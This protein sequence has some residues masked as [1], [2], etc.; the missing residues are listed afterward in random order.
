MEYTVDAPEFGD[1]RVTVQTSSLFSGPKLLVDET[2]ATKQGQQYLV[3]VANGQT[4]PVKLKTG[5]DPVPVVEI[6]GRQIRLVEPLK[7]YEYVWACLPLLLIGLGGAIGGAIGGATAWANMALFRAQ[8]N[9]AARYGLSALA[10]VGA[11]V[12]WFVLA[13]AII[14]TTRR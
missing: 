5:F 3:P 1:R 2:P 14:G 12:L 13:V 7:W 4:I 10:T 8:T 11:F 6:A 9:P